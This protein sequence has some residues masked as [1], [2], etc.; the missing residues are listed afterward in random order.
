MLIRQGDSERDLRAPAL[1]SMTLRYPATG[2]FVS[3]QRID[4]IYAAGVF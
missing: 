3:Q 4:W 2:I 1:W